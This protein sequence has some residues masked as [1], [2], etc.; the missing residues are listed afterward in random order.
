MKQSS[1]FPVVSARLNSS[2][3]TMN[4]SRRG[5]FEPLH[6]SAA[7]SLP[8]VGVRGE[9]RWQPPGIGENTHSRTSPS[10][11]EKKLGATYADIPHQ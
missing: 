2:F 6:S 7:A 3:T 4:S 10:P 8:E 5:I 9:S 1:R 11:G